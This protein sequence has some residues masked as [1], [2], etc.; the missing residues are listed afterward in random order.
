M[1][2][3]NAG[4]IVELDDENASPQGG[5]RRRAL[6]VAFALCLAVGSAFVGRD[7]RPEA[8]PSSETATRVYDRTGETLLHRLPRSVVDVPFALVR[9]R[10]TFEVVPVLPHGEDAAFMWTQNRTAYWLITLRPI[11]SVIEVAD[12]RR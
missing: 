9:T 2:A 8:A 5:E 3:V 1:F 7:G 4:S 6:V 10:A 12:K 11:D